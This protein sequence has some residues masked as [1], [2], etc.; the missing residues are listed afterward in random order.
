M[1]YVESCGTEAGS[2]PPLGS[3]RDT[4]AGGTAAASVAGAEAGKTWACAFRAGGCRAV[5][6]AGRGGRGG[7]AWASA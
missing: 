6:N 4:G 3:G 5:G 2:G 1:R 7:F